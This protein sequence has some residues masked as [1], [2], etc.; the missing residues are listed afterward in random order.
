MGELTSVFGSGGHPQEITRF[1]DIMVAGS[2]EHRTAFAALCEELASVTNSE[3]RLGQATKFSLISTECAGLFL[4]ISIVERLGWADR[5][6][7]LS[8]K[9]ANGPRLLTYT[10]AGL[11]LE[12]LGR[13]DEA[14]AYLD[15]GLALFSGW[16]DAPD[17]GGLRRFFASEP[18]KTRRDLLVELLGD[19]VAEEDLIQRQ[20]G[21]DRLANHLIREFAGRIRGFGR[22]SRS[23]VVKNFLALPGRLRVEETRLLVTFTSSPLNAVLHLSRLDDPVEGVS[24]IGG[25]RIEFEPYGV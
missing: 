5:L 25:R 18:A 11:G 7:Q 17:L 19:N 24:W 15:P 16:L 23:F 13:F 14:P 21:F 2:S 20:G 10:L 12:I 4:L 9:A 1:W 22:S 3:N 6:G 8:F